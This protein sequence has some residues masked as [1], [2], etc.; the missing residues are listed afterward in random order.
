MQI[1]PATTIKNL[2]YEQKCDLESLGFIKFN[3]MMFRASRNIN[4][5][6]YMHRRCKKMYKPETV[7][8]TYVKM[9]NGIIAK[10]MTGR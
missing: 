1:Y 3:G 4:D 7:R 5:V 2:S 6:M 9:K 8:L 10:E